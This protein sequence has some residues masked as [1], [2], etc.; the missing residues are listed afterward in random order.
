MTY[1]ESRLASG[2]GGTIT[3]TPKQTRFVAEFLVDL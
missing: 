3:M 1:A 2:P